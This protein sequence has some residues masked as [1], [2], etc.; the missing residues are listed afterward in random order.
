M[1][2]RGALVVLVAA[3]GDSAARVQLAPVSPCGATANKTAMRVVAYTAGGELRRTVPPNEIDAFPADT[4]QLGVEV[5]GG[6]AG[7]LIAIGKTGPLAFAA[8]E[9]GAAI[10]I[11][12][13]PPDGLCPVGPMT[14]PRVAPVVARAGRGV[15]VVGGTSPTGEPLST[16]EYYDPATATFTPVTVPPNLADADNGLAG[17][18]LSELPDGRVAL[19]GTSSHVLAT[20]AADESR[21]PMP[22][23]F[24]HRA[25]HG[26]IA[27][28]DDHLFIIGGCADVAGSACSGPTL[29]TGFVYDMRDVANRERGPQLGDTA[30]RYGARIFDLGVQLDGV[31]RFVL[32]GGFGAA[33]EGDRF[34]ITDGVT[35]TITGM[36]AQHALLDGGALLSA[37]ERDG[38]AQTGAAGVLVPDGGIA[39]LALAPRVD[40]ARLVTLED[41]SVLAVGGAANLA[42]YVPTTNTWTMV[43]PE[44]GG[45]ALPALAAPVLTRLDDG[46][47][48]VLGGSDPSEQAWIYRPSLV[49]PS[50]GSVVALPDGSTDGV[51]TASDPTLLDRRAG[52]FVLAAGDDDYRARAL[53]GGPRIADGSVGAV[54]RAT[55]GGVAL[56]AQQTGPG[57]ALV[58]RLVPGEPARILRLDAGT[59]TTLCTG[60]AVNESDIAIPVTFSVSAGTATLSVGATGASTA[61]VTCAVTASERGAWGLAAAGTGARIEVGPV[62]VTRTR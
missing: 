53:V 29:R 33:G 45:A 16:A 40:G 19:T 23:L 44:T 57:R 56:I 58:G 39:P 25:F 5:I 10:P 30:Q 1:F 9:D 8:L 4:E 26:A 59:E 12:M 36:H 62:T 35:E 43:V 48:L 7:E 6:S 28:D 32:A 18:V 50:S 49:G 17:A 41:G 60:A 11:V 15:L 21:L 2:A 20:F 37:F 55:G 46:S 27:L 14:E 31:H 52:R 22:V 51:L 13:A 42:R 38:T 54:V 24:D 47:V 34:A 61:K 3:C